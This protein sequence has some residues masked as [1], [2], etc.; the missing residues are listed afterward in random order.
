M[1]SSGFEPRSYG[2]AVSVANHYTGWSHT[3]TA[4]IKQQHEKAIPVYTSK[5][6]SILPIHSAC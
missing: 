3:E 2:T 6:H 5:W 4:N 1:P